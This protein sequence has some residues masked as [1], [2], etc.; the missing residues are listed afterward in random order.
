MTSF[1]SIAVFGATGDLGPYLVDALLESKAFT[2]IKVLTRLETFEEKPQTFD[3][4]KARGVQ[5]EALDLKNEN[6][7]VEALQ[8][9][10][11][12]VSSIGGKVLANQLLWVKAAAKA[13]VR[14]FIPSEFG[15]NSQKATGPVFETK[16][17]VKEAIVKNGMEYTLLF[18][19][20]FADETVI[21][22]FGFDV[23]EGTVRLVGDSS[24][25]LTLTYRKDIASFIVE[26]L[27]NPSVSRNKALQVQSVQTSFD[28]I[29]ERFKAA[30]N[31]LKVSRLTE[32]EAQ[33]LIDANPNT[34]T[35]FYIMLLI[36]AAH[37]D[38]YFDS[39]D[40]ALFP[41]V[42]PSGLDVAV[43]EAIESAKQ[44]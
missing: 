23:K 10:D 40:N 21:P 41:N 18:V 2:T 7:V 6:A 42:K 11:A 33:E 32:A 16:R 37:G 13:G 3:D 9:I 30:G 20:L 12:V 29:I 31:P 28:E 25:P 34:V 5:V 1:K 27:N 15:I 26:I 39:V 14:R 8:G 38:M 44:L 17:A 24:V 19:S 4:L 22:L 35:S 43:Q 36:K